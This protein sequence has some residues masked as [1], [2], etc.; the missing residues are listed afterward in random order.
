M[1]TE[2]LNNFIRNKIL[3]ELHTTLSPGHDQVNPKV[4]FELV[5]VI[6]DPLYLILHESFNRNCATTTENRS[7]IKTGNKT[8]AFKYRPVSLTSV[9]CK[10]M[11][12]L[13]R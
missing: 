3:K 5:D 12:K 10:V 1:G 9:V 8:S 2:D 4:L 13:V 6:D 11:E 7:Y